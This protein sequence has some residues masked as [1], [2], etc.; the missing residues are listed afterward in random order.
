M[1]KLKNQEGIIICKLRIKFYIRWIV[2]RM[3]KKAAL[4]AFPWVY[5]TN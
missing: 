3:N 2:S 1:N 4:L 5:L